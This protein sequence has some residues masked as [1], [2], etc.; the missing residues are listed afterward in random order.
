MKQL[1]SR[2]SMLDWL[3]VGGWW[4]PFVSSFV[5]FSFVCLLLR[6]ERSLKEDIRRVSILHMILN[7]TGY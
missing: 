7:M 6:K 3:V 1:D 4:V 2:L 5:V